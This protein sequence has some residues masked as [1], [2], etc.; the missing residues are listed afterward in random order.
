MNIEFR[1]D[2]LG[3]AKE[4]GIASHKARLAF[5]FQNEVE[6]PL[7]KRSLPFHRLFTCFHI[8][9]HLRLAFELSVQEHEIAQDEGIASLF[10]FDTFAAG[11]ANANPYGALEEPHGAQKLHSCSRVMPSFRRIRSPLH[12]HYRS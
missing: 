8:Q 11:L 5:A 4:S 9:L 12:C 2:L 1:T 10:I 6:A 3:A 7:Q